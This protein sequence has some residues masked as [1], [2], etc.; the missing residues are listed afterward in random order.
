MSQQ[1]SVLQQRNGSR[2]KTISFIFILGCLSAFGPLT[3]DMYLPGLPLLSADLQTSASNAQLSLTACFIGMALGQV[4]IGPFSDI[5][6]R[7]GP[8][9]ISLI[10]YS[11]A[12]LLCIFTPSI[13]VFILLRLI[14]GLSGA[15]GIVIARASL[16]D[17]YSGPEM[18]KYFSMLMLV[19]GLAPILAPVLGGVIL[20]YTSWR[21]IF[22]VLAGIGLFVFVYVLFGLN[23]TLSKEMRKTG[24][25]QEVFQTF[26]VL[27]RDRTFVGFALIQAFVMGALFAYLSASSF[28]L[29]EIYGLSPQAFS[30]VF[31]A[32]SIGLIVATQVT[33][34]LAGKIKLVSMLK[35]GMSL[36]IISSVL[37]LIGTLLEASVVYISVLLFLALSCVGVINT[38]VFP[39]AMEKQ[40]EHAG[41]ASALLGLLPFI[42]GALV[43]PL[44]GLGNAAISMAIVIT[45]CELLAIMSYVFLV[46][47]T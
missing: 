25:L 40:G 47:R 11:V 45:V 1:Q 17:V 16:R 34:R 19:M 24:G 42:N 27:L 13:W 26:G 35:F 46:R 3:I 20:E 36:S 18:T 23:E 2:L 10:V 44:V 32:N 14:Q 7:K 30:I 39:L 8:L 33:G 38:T 28:V 9:V 6:G 43:A 37:L 29:Q 15:A 5:K 21:G 12:S 31:A 22:G 4:L 41:S